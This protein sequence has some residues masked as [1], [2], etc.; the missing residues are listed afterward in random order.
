MAGTIRDLY[1]SS[2]SYIKDQVDWLYHIWTLRPL[3]SHQELLAQR[4]KGEL[5]ASHPEEAGL[6]ATLDQVLGNE[7]ELNIED[8]DLF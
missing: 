5:I 8:L 7:P 6:I 4:L 1:P 2:L 3:C